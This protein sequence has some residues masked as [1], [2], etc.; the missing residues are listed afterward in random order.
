MMKYRAFKKSIGWV[1]VILLLVTMLPSQHMHAGAETTVTITGFISGATS[2][3]R[4]SELLYAKVEGYEGNT[5]NLTY[6]WI[7]NLGSVREGWFGIKNY[8]GTYLYVYN[9][10]NMYTVQGTDGEQEIHNTAMGVDAMEPM[11]EAGRSHDQTFTGVG[12]AY[13]AVYGANLNSRG[14]DLQ[15][16]ITVEVY[17]GK[18]LIGRAT[19]GGFEEPDLGTDLDNAVFGVFVGDTIDVK[20]LLGESAIVHINCTANSVTKATI[21][22]GSKNIR[23]SGSTPNYYVTGL[24]KGVSQISITLEKENCKFHQYSSASTSPM[25]HVFR[26]PSVTP[27]LTTLTL[28]DLDPDCTYYIGNAKGERS[29]DGNTVVF[30]GLNPSTTYE[31]EVR[32]H[33]TDEGEEKVVYAFVQ[34]TTLTPN[35]A[36]VVIRLDGT[37][38]PQ[39]QVGLTGMVLR[40]VIDGAVSLESIPLTYQTGGNYTAPVGN[41]IYYIYDTKGERLGLDQEIVINN[42]DAS[43]TLNYYSVTYETDGGTLVNTPLVSI[44][45]QSDTVRTTEEIPVKSGYYFTGWKWEGTVYPAATV[46]TDD[47]AAP[48]VLTAQWQDAVDVTVNIEIHH[49]SQNGAGH[50]NDNGKHDITFTVDGRDPLTVGDYTEYAATSIEWD[51][52]TPFDKPGYD[53]LHEL[54]DDTDITYYNATAPTFTDLPQG[55][56]FTVTT[57]KSGYDLQ[58]IQQET[59]DEGN[60]TLTVTLFYNPDVFDFTFEVELEEQAKGLPAVMKPI[61]ANVKVTMWHDSPYVDGEGVDWYTISQ[62][63]ET[64]IQVNLDENGWG[65]GSYPVWISTTDHYSA[66]YYRVEVI[67]FLMPDRSLLPMAD[68]QYEHTEYVSADQRYVATIEVTDGKDPVADDQSTLTG[69]WYEDVSDNGVSDAAQQGS[70]KAWISIE[71]PTLTLDAN[72]GTIGSSATTKAQIEQIIEVPALDDY[73]PTRDGYV[74]GGWYTADGA[75]IAEGD[76]IYQDTTAYAAWSEEMRITGRVTAQYYYDHYGVLTYIPQPDR[77]SYTEVLLRRRVVGADN[78]VTVAEQY[79]QFDTGENEGMADFAFEHLPSTTHT[80]LA[81]E[82][83]VEVRQANYTETYDPAYSYTGY[84]AAG[85][86]FTDHAAKP[87]IENGKGTA[88]VVLSFAPEEFVVDFQV[89]MT[90]IGN[91]GSR[92]TSVKVVYEA[93]AN[94]GALQWTVISQHSGENQ[95]LTASVQNGYATGSYPVWSRTPDGTYEYLYRL[96]VVSY[97]MPDGTEIAVDS[98]DH[99]LFNI[100]YGDAVSVASQ[101]PLITAAFAPLPLRIT[102]DT[103]LPDA[104]LN[105]HGY[106]E[107]GTSSEGGSVYTGYFYYGSGVESF[108]V[109][110]KVDYSFEGWYTA[111]GTPVTSIDPDTAEEVYLYAH[112]TEG[113]TV[114]F[115]ANNPYAHEDLLRCYHPLDVTLDG[116]HPHRLT[117]EGKLPSHFYDLP[118]FSYENHNKYI[119]KGW[120]QDADNNDDSRPIDWN[121]AFTEETDI[122]A[123][124]IF[125]DT[126]MQ[127]RTDTKRTSGDGVYQGFDLV[128]AQIRTAEKD[129]LEHYG[130]V[131]SG[132]RFVTVISEKTY[133]QILNL[134]LSNAADAEYGFVLGK[135]TSAEK[136][137]GEQTDHQMEYKSANTNGVDTTVSH[138]YVA[139]IKCSGLKEDHFNCDDYRLYTA[140]VTYKNKEGQAL[141]DAQASKLIARSYIRYYD[142]NGLYRT[143]YNNYTGTPVYNGCQTSYTTVAT[144]LGITE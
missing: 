22:S 108:P 97:T 107:T 72:G 137:V 136:V 48:M 77:L 118:A 85:N 30:E 27:G 65:Q 88:S 14:Y 54:T 6:K 26:K 63:K 23:V 75:A 47:I 45:R 92:P 7:N 122:Y 74:F 37:M 69:A 18:T 121:Q 41:G 31:I 33:Y 83:I 2:G 93:A 126:V 132:L 127:D 20:D 17:D 70:V 139:N 80:G 51:G 105:A 39:E 111:D 110:A 61:A 34:G 143:Y 58:D 116:D 104:R 89:D 123:H 71:K 130:E 95:P 113:Y 68:K 60:V 12:Y 98:T 76:A 87:V 142:A 90:R 140:V 43:S 35:I 133:Q 57:T 99:T 53:A 56:E 64:Y 128:G 25:V 91:E 52:S 81:Y 29:A 120:Y 109:P 9:S 62:H 13:A 78:Y 73:M 135:A 125:V 119:F 36:A 100:Y 32:G 102:L 103:V 24:Q 67:S 28:T 3:L 117:E 4:S 44:Y 144:L 82:Y 16:N 66:Y 84:D 42:T 40:Q 8:Y 46:V 138:S 101:T 19:Y 55:L 134:H 115:H 86:E 114:N 38:V 129:H 10:H 112:W 94:N 49:I 59:D 1:L 11:A 15:G 50:N 5:A 106:T 124:W 131:G 79:V 96:K 21:I 141:A